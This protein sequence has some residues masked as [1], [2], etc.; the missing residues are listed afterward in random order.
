MEALRPITVVYS[1]E[2]TKNWKQWCRRSVG[3]NMNQQTTIATT[4]TTNNK[5]LNNKMKTTDD[6]RR[7]QRRRRGRQ[8]LWRG[9]RGRGPRQNTTTNCSPR[10]RST[11]PQ[12]LESSEG[13]FQTQSGLRCKLG[14]PN[15]LIATTMLQT[16]C[17]VIGVTPQCYRQC[18]VRGCFQN[19]AK[20]ITNHVEWE[21][22]L[23]ECCQ[24]T[25]SKRQRKCGKQHRTI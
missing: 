17:Q 21:I 5:N 15:T 1:F 20:T 4:I 19:A 7:Q 8:G 12:T 22:L 2:L 24:W 6:P 10:S 9:G 11:L 3:N 18:Q 16:Q 25:Q 14:S 13:K 23:P